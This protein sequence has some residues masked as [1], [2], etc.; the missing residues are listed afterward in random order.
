LTGQPLL[1][2]ASMGNIQ[3]RLL[4]T[5]YNIAEASVGLAPQLVISLGGSATTES[6]LNLPG[7]P[8]VVEY[9]PQLELLQKAEQSM[10]H[11]EMNITLESLTNGVPMVAIPINDIPGVA[12]PIVRL[13]CG[14]AVPLKKLN[15]SR[16][17]TSIHNVLTEDA[18]QRNALMLQ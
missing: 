1:I 10:I 11:S 4:G 3:N 8:L 2:Y 9:A 5:F 6:R 15:V 14:E 18:E 7:S 13:G 12:A 17:I 16:L